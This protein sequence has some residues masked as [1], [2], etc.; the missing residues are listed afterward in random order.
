MSRSKSGDK[1]PGYEYWG[2]RSSK[3]KGLREPGAYTK[4]ITHKKERR[5][6]KKDSQSKDN[7]ND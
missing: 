3:G 1:S 7:S 5:Q 6:G 4:K 2:R